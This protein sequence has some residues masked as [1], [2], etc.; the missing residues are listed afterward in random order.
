MVEGQPVSL[1]TQLQP[2]EQ[3]HYRRYIVDCPVHWGVDRNKCR[4]RRNLV[5]GKSIGGSLASAAFLGV[6]VKHARRF[7]NNK[8]H[9][10]Y[11]PSDAEVARFMMENGMVSVD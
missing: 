2:G 8:K 10:A 11:Q 5:L 4:R 7:G 6:W 3:C 9:Q 1:E